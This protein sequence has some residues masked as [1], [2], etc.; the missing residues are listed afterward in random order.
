MIRELI[1]NEG[2]TKKPDPYRLILMNFNQGQDNFAFITGHWAD[3]AGENGEW[4][5]YAL[6]QPNPHFVLE[7]TLNLHWAYLTDGFGYLVDKGKAAL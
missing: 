4:I 1:W 5:G 6:N 7:K 3:R 2:E